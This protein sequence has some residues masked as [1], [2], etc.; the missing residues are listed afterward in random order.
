MSDAKAA[1][2]SAA[3]VGSVIASMAKCPDFISYGEGMKSCRVQPPKILSMA[4]MWQAVI[5]LV[6]GLVFSQDFAKKVMV[7]V[8]EQNKEKWLRPLSEQEVV[9]YADR[10]GKRFRTMA[11]HINKARNH[12]PRPPSWVLQIVGQLS[13]TSSAPAVSSVSAP[14][15]Y[16]TG[17]DWEWKMAWRAEADG[18]RKIMSPAFAQGN[19]VMAVFQEQ[20]PIAISGITIEELAEMPP[21]K[22][23]R[24]TGST[25]TALWEGHTAEGERLHLARFLNKYQR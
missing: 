19:E 12:K 5:P 10:M 16:L 2:A 23:Q 6:P 11:K 15:D 24:Q 13:P 3:A 7:E 21:Q 22:Q 1:K 20:P 18:S 17:F 8:A 4:K 9:D 25:K 14:L